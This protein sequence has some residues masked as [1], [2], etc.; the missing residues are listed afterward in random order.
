MG[1]VKEHYLDSLAAQAEQDE[2]IPASFIP[3]VKTW[4]FGAAA[5]GDS[6]VKSYPLTVGGMDIVLNLQMHLTL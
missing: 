6:D 2:M 1:K 3:Q 5:Q 4:K